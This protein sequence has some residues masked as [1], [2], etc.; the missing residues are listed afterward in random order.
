MQRSLELENMLL[1]WKKSN[2]KKKPS[3]ELKRKIDCT[4]TVVTSSNAN[5]VRSTP[6]KSPKDSSETPVPR[7]K[8]DGFQ[9]QM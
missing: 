3:T 6:R 1:I 5:T 2:P 4:K 7:V 8:S 9:L